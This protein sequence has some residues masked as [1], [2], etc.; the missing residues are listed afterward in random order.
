MRRL[1]NWFVP[2]RRTNTSSAHRPRSFRPQVEQLDERLVPSNLGLSSAVSTQHSGA[3]F[4]HPVSWT[5]QDVYTI[6]GNTGQ[7]VEY[8]TNVLFA[9]THYQYNLGGPSNVF[10]VSATIDPQNS[11]AEVFAL[12]LS[13]YQGTIPVGNLWLCDPSGTW[14]ELGGLFTGISATHDG[15]VYGVSSGNGDVWYADANNNGTDLGSPQ[16]SSG[17]GVG[18]N[19]SSSSLAAS[20]SWFGGNEVF[21]LGKDNAIYVNAANTSGSWQLVSNQATFIALSASTNDT[22]FALTLPSNPYVGS[23]ETLYEVTENA[24]PGRWLPILYWSPQAI[25]GNGAPSLAD[26]QISADTDTSGQAEVYVTDAQSNLYLDDQGSWTETYD[27]GLYDMAAAGDGYLYAVYPAYGSFTAWMYGPNGNAN[28]IQV[29][30]GVD[31][32]SQ[33]AYGPL[34]AEYAITANETDY[35]G[36]DVQTVLGLPTAAMTEPVSDALKMTFHGGAIYWSPSTGAHAVYGLIGSSYT[37]LGGPESNLGLPT[38]DEEEI[39]GGIGRFN[40][41][42][43]GTI[44]WTPATGTYDLILQDSALAAAEQSG[45]PNGII[46]RTAM[47]AVY[48]KVENQGSV[49]AADFADLQTLVA[50]PSYVMPDYVRDLANKVV[51]GNPANAYY[52]NLIPMGNLYAGSSSLQFQELV[53]KWFLGTDRPDSDSFTIDY[54]YASGTLF[55]NSGPAYSDVWQGDIGDCYYLASLAEIAYQSPSS[56]Q[57]MFIDNGDN[58]Y[59]VRFY[60]NGVAD[61]VTVDRYLPVDSNGYFLHDNRPYQYSDSQDVLWVALAEKAYAQLAEEGWSRGPGAINSYASLNNGDGGV[62][63]SQISGLAHSWQSYANATDLANAFN[64]GKLVTL[65]TNGQDNQV[66][67]NIVSDHCYALLTAN[68]KADQFTLFNP[69]GLNGGYEGGDPNFKPGKVTLT[70]AELQASFSG[71]AEAGSNPG[72][73]ASIQA[74]LARA[75][76]PELN[77]RLLTA[78]LSPSGGEQSVPASVPVT[79][80]DHAPGNISRQTDA[81][82]RWMAQVPYSSG[83]LSLDFDPLAEPIS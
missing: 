35:G 52:H 39:A 79:M 13:S 71:W 43:S 49:S 60:N 51:N 3:L 2:A 24:R 8:R 27:S 72:T 17:T 9:G 70:W 16:T 83:L 20:V 80:T 32:S 77:A 18:E 26:A 76:G 81:V 22:V 23:G 61:Y 21:V 30:S 14:H 29:G 58:T 4:G 48:Q 69:W 38:T 44:Y 67:A 42:Q 6:D 28:A 31:S 73:S 11:D 65:G 34:G 10:A 1:R 56:I 25:T 19:G 41:F 7:V 40:D 63:T 57:Q 64:S 66:A 74:M 82:A 53:G 15:H 12:S 54:Q 75:Q 37:S 68:A 62:A 55:G 47:L 36:R 78:G 59:T 33:F 5:E 45:A 50:T 46:G